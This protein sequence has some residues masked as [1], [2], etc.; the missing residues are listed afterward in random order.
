[1]VTW[2]EYQA[3]KVCMEIEGVYA[4]DI[5]SIVV[6]YVQ[7]SAGPVKR[8]ELVHDVSVKDWHQ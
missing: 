3:Y 5:E 4:P 2:E 6:G 8:E 7:K 1:M